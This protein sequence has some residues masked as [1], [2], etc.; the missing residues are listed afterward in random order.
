M[1]MVPVAYSPRYLADIGPHVFQ[2]Q[3]YRLTCERL[4]QSHRLQV[5]QVLEPPAATFDDA[6]LVH[7]LAYLRDLSGVRHTPLT[8]PSELPLTPE[9][10]ASAYLAAGG[11][12][13]AC[14]KAIEEGAAVNL[15]GGFHH[16]FPHHAEGFC[17]LNDIAI[18]IRRLQRD[19]RIERAAVVDLDLHQGNGTAFIFHEDPRVFTFSMHQERLYPLKQRSTLDV[20]LENGT[21]DAE[22]LRLLREHLPRI[23]DEHR[24][25]LVVYQAGVDPYRDDQ[26][27]DLDMTAEG[28]FARDRFVVG[29]C[30]ARNI[31]IAGLLG[32][33]YAS[34]PED[35]VSLHVQTCLA[36]LP[37]V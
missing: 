26:L 25:E 6:R 8:L 12:L 10:I 18:A 21:G 14:R 11:T 22:Y 35:T 20:G 15:G 1:P 17:Y 33:G 7:T 5:G 9:I 29:E 16:A 24:P 23:L 4:L 32:G 36:F 3:K 28:L 31:P 34:N 13:L 37:N 27:G 30:R 2:I 19:A